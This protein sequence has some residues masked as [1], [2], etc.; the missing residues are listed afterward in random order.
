M[1]KIPDVNIYKEPKVDSPTMLAAWPGMGAVATQAVDYIRKG[2]LMYL[3]LLL[4]QK[5]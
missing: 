4:F 3:I 2:L 1:L 5:G